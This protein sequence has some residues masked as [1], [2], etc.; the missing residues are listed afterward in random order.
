MNTGIGKRLVELMGVMEMNQQKFCKLS[1][2]KISTFSSVCLGKSLPGFEFLEKL[3]LAFPLVN[4]RWL[5]CGEEEMF[6][7]TVFRKSDE[8]E[9]N[10]KLQKEMLRKY[11]ED[12]IR[13]H[14]MEKHIIKIAKDMLR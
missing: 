5:L 14:E 4:M 9:K 2:I 7:L 6:T 11:L 8:D 10:F 3:T 13:L 12:R 1:G